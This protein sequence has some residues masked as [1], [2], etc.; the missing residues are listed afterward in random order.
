[1]TAGDPNGR[2]IAFLGGD[3]RIPAAAEY[4]A[5][6]H[7]AEC[8]LFG[9]DR[10]GEYPDILTRAV[11]PEDAVRSA[12][13]VV[14][15]L[16]VSRDGLNIYAPFAAKEILLV[17]VLSLV[18][19]DQVL[20]GGRIDKRICGVHRRTFDYYE[21][22]ELKVLNAVPTAEGAIAIAMDTLKITLHGARAVV[23]GFGRVGKALSFRLSSLGA[24]VC[25][26]A[27]RESDRAF[28]ESEGMQ[29]VPFAAAG[30]ALQSADCVFNTVPHPAVEGETLARIPAGVPFIELASPPGGIDKGSPAAEGINVIE[31]PALPGKCAPVTAGKIIGRAAAAILEE[32]G[33]L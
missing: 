19:E 22:E 8:A 3:A 26:C 31:A 2:K 28:A 33:V 15:P 1:M 32:E 14:L 21:R 4:L 12:C 13:A 23:L 6:T 11:T 10:E 24:K 5:R 30:D 20:L 18:N 16:P 17:P 7:G 27:R 29:S 25:V 9:F